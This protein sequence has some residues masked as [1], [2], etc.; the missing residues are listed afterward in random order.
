MPTKQT[1]VRPCSASALF[2]YRNVYGKCSKVENI[3]Q[4]PLELGWIDDLRFYVLFNSI[5]V[6]SGRWVGDHERL[7]AMEPCLCLNG[8][9]PLAG[10]ETRTVR[11]ANQ[12]LTHCAAGAPP[13]TMNDLTQMI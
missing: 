7:C 12:R 6:K 10:L 4:K 13:K 3:D 5:S 8:S 1:H 9:P 2:P 11:S